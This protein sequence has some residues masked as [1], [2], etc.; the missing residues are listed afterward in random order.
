MIR[1]LF[2]L[3]SLA[4][5]SSARNVSDTTIYIFTIDT[6][7]KHNPLKQ[8]LWLNAYSQVYLH[9]KGIGS[10]LCGVAYDFKKKVCWGL[11]LRPEYN[12]NSNIFSIHFEYIGEILHYYSWPVVV[13]P[14]ITFHKERYDFFC[15]GY[16]YGY[17]FNIKDLI[18]VNIEIHM[19]DRILLNTISNC[20]FYLSPYLSLNFKFFSIFFKENIIISRKRWASE[21]FSTVLGVDFIIRLF[22]K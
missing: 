8:S 7:N 15:F 13:D 12:L 16:G 21:F 6:T 17:Q 10:G 22:E 14:T 1:I 9:E 2:F 4:I 20:G 3:F 18:K 11:G 5:I 19:S